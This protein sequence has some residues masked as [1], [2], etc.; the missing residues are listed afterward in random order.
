MVGRVPRP[1]ADALVGL[2]CN[3]VTSPKNIFAL[4]VFPNPCNN[5]GSIPP[6]DSI[7]AGLDLPPA[8]GN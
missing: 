2:F 6:L 8:H 5:P 4:A 7:A 1:A 3:A